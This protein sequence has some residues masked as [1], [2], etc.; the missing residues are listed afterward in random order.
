M[1]I[2]FNL[3][4]VLQVLQACKS[5]SLFLSWLLIHLGH[6]LNRRCHLRSLMRRIRNVKANL[7]LGLGIRFLGEIGFYSRWFTLDQPE[8]SRRLLIIGQQLSWRR[9]FVLSLTV[10]VWTGSASTD[11]ASLAGVLTSLYVALVL[12]LHLLQVAH[13]NAFNAVLSCSWILLI[14]LETL[15]NQELWCTNVWPQTFMDQ[16][17]WR[18][19][20]LRRSLRHDLARLDDQLGTWLGPIIHKNVLYIIL[21]VLLLILYELNNLINVFLLILIRIMYIRIFLVLVLAGLHRVLFTIA[22]RFHILVNART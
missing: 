20:I 17:N 16:I 2:D 10:A 1:L 13:R 19:I 11:W 14:L 6:L 18:R 12:R 5:S 4:D 3:A 7:A 9:W 8:P 22:V 21:R 15:R